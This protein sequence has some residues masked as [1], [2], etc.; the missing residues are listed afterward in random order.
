MSCTSECATHTLKMNTLTTTG[1]QL[2]SAVILPT[3]ISVTSVRFAPYAPIPMGAMVKQQKNLQE[4]STAAQS[5]HV[6][7]TGGK[8]Q[9]AQYAQYAANCISSNA[10]SMKAPLAQPMASH[11]HLVIYVHGS[12]ATQGSRIHAG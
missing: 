1:I 11:I 2:R 10:Q 3:G 4:D 9:D 6:E 7:Q 8:F 5:L 12:H